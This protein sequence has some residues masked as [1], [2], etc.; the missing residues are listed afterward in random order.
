M[1]KDLARYIQEI[2]RKAYLQ[3]A[4]DASNGYIADNDHDIDVII[5]QIGMEI[6]ERERDER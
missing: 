5:E 1:N 4:S 2:C 6:I 3:G